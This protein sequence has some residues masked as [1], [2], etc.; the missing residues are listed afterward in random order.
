MTTTIDNS[1]VLLIRADASVRMGTGHVMRCLGLAQAWQDRGGRVV[2]AIAEC[3]AG[4]D[5]RLRSEQVEIVR[6]EVD[7]GSEADARA[8]VEAARNC[9][10]AWVV[11][12]GYHF[13]ARFHEIIK[14]LGS[15][16]LSVDDFGTLEHYWADIVLNQDPIANE[17]LYFRREPYTQ[18]LLGN[19]YTFLRREFRQQIRSRRPI[20]PIARKL[21]VT[22]GGSDPDNVTRKVIACLN[23]VPLE[24]LDVIVL[25]GPSNPHG[26]SLHAAVAQC[27]R[28]VRLLRNPPNIPELIASCD[29]AVTAGGSTVWELAYFYVP[30]IV[31]LVAENQEPAMGLLHERGACV[32]LGSGSQMTS[33]QL[34]TTISVLCHDAI[35]RASL[36]AQL[37]ATIDGQGTERV[38]A[39][40]LENPFQNHRDAEPAAGT[41]VISR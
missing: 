41:T 5:E 20:P 32:R 28:N 6:L 14:Q 36:S 13:D 8:T 38:C 9:G 10:S 31:L 30:S 19:E 40:L 27:R 2:C 34:S 17:M 37:G 21:L 12:D 35:R 3:S 29:L 11:A 25:V 26:E 24:Y 18:L 23:D 39:A 7:P 15:R 1:P 4:L 22:L 33:E 16:L